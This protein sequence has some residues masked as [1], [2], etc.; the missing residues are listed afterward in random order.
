MLMG[1]DHA[2]SGPGAGRAR[3]CRLG[4]A[5]LLGGR[6]RRPGGSPGP[7]WRPVHAQG[8]CRSPGS[9]SST[10]SGRLDPAGVAAARAARLP[11]DVRQARHDLPARGRHRRCC[12]PSSSMPRSRASSTAAARSSRARCSRSASSPSPAARSRGSTRCR[13]RHDAEAAHAR[14]RRPHRRLRRDAARVLRRDHGDGRRGL[15]PPGVYFAINT[16]PRRCEWIAVATLG[17]PVTAPQMRQL[18]AR[19]GEKTVQPAPAARPP[20][21]SGM[22]QIFAALLGGRPLAGALV[23]LRHHVRGAVH[24]DDARRRHARRPLHA[25]GHAAA[26]SGRRWAHPSLARQ[27]LDQRGSSSRPGATSSIGGV[28][29]PLRR[30]HMRSGR[31][32][33]SPTSCSPASRSPSERPSSCD[34]ADPVSPG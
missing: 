28:I 18:A 7:R 10:A 32:S 29:D 25:A 33:A 9:S 17:F 31:C 13:L 26:T 22:A 6:S 19:V 15:L 5:L 23:P 24:P 3:D 12:G 34:W 4:R 16:R 27:R 11:L 14:E 1:A 30:H 2:R 20:S 21:R 8:A